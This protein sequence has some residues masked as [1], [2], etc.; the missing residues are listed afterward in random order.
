MLEREITMDPNAALDCEMQ[1]ALEQV[2]S[3]NVFQQLLSFDSALQALKPAREALKDR[4]R[5]SNGHDSRYEDAQQRIDEFD[6]LIRRFEGL[7]TAA[8]LEFN[9]RARPRLRKLGVLHLP[10]ELLLGIFDNFKGS[11]YWDYLFLRRLTHNM[12]TIQNARL[13]C[14][15]FCDNSSHL[16]VPYLYVSPTP[17]SLKRLEQVTSHPSISRG[18]CLLKISA[19]FYSA[20]IAN[21]H[22][23]FA[24]MCYRRVQQKTER[25]EEALEEFGGLTRHGPESVV[26][27]DVE[28]ARHILSC[29]E[30]IA[31]GEDTDQVNQHDPAVAAILRGHRR[32]RENFE[33]HENM[34][35]DSFFAR[36]VAAAT[37]RSRSRIW[38]DISD[39]Y[40]IGPQPEEPTWSTTLANPALLADPGLLVE[41]GL[42][43]PRMWYHARGDRAHEAPQSL[44]YE[45]PLEMRAAGA[46]LLGVRVDLSRP[47]VFTPNLS[48]AQISGLNEAF[49][50][51]RDFYFCLSSGPFYP[52]DNLPSTELIVGLYT[53]LSAAIGRQSFQNL[54]LNLTC[55][56]EAVLRDNDTE[57]YSIAPLLTSSAWSRIK[58]LQL[59]NAIMH[60][61]DLETMIGMLQPGV[62]IQ[63]QLIHLISGTWEEAL[64]CIRLKAGWGSRVEGG[65]YGAEAEAMPDEEF[66]E[67]FLLH[68][69]PYGNLASQYIQSIEGV[70]NPLRRDVEAAKADSGP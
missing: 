43:E 3:D 42:A 65:V 1:L 5:V 41:S 53:Y 33:Q 68:R 27:A 39:A 21:N 44:L 58:V 46:Q 34:L 29:W 51:L 12:E 49:K 6:A 16:L 18:L 22:R 50:E 17:S 9:L 4:L 20:A 28:K 56:S 66:D 26:R 36:A 2:D 47:D 55:L 67:V 24:R 69:E 59:S 63:L 37:A 10:D 57:K 8:R 11:M 25:L 19:R 31:F 13:T 54:H 60:L 64:D 38:L 14:R 35:R 70:E 52:R 61:D 40:D 62:N 30:P 32:Y 48:T 45:L 23:E 15:R 7:Q